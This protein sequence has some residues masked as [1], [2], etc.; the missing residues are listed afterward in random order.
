M[1]EIVEVARRIPGV[2]REVALLTK[3]FESCEIDNIACSRVDEGASSKALT[4]LLKFH[5]RQGTRKELAGAL[6]K[7]K[8][9]SLAENVLTGSFIDD[10]RE[11]VDF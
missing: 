4:M 10:S 6:S 7:I 1:E 5:E 11:R 2:W 9:Q 3:Q 8:W